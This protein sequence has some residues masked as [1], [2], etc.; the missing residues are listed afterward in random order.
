MSDEIRASYWPRVVATTFTTNSSSLARQS[1]VAI[2]ASGDAAREVL[3][4]E[5]DGALV[6]P[7]TA[8]QALCEL[9]TALLRGNGQDALAALVLE[10]NRE[11]GAE[12]TA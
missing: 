1:L 8:E 11:N 7:G 9:V 3:R 5:A 10:Q 2:D 6:Y 4:V 12:T